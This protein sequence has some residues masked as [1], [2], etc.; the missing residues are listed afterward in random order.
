MGIRQCEN[1]GQL[2][3][4][5]IRNTGPQEPSVCPELLEGGVR[6][7]PRRPEAVVGQGARTTQ[8]IVS[9]GVVAEDASLGSQT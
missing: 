8:A 3:Q 9:S 7:G 2:P 1:Q 6:Q 5:C 4:R